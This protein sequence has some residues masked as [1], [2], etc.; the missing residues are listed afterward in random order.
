MNPFGLIQQRFRRLSGRSKAVGMFF[1]TSLT[2]RA[3]GICCQLFQV[4][5]AVKA[6]GAEAFGLWMTL[7][8][9]GIMITFADFGMGQG[10]QNKLAEAF[11]SGNERLARELGGSVAVFLGSLALLLAAVVGV[12]VPLLNFTALFNLTDPVVQAQAPHAILI[13][14]LLFCVNFPLG[15][16]QRLAYSRQR[17]WMHNIA[18][19]LGGLGS[20]GGVL[21][22]ARLHLGLAAFIAAA[23]IPFILANAGLLSLQLIQLGWF[24]LH[25]VHC[26]WA[27]IR[28]LLGLGAYFGVQQVQLVLML[29]LPQLIISTSLGA[30]AVTPYNLAQRLFNLFAIIQNAF[31]LP[32]WPAYSDAKARG[33]FDWIRRTL[34]FSLRATALCTIAPM[35]IGALFA[36]KLLALWVGGHGALPSESLVW[37]L[38]LWNALVFLQQTFGYLLAGLSEVRRLTFYAVIS[39]AASAGLM[40]LLVHHYAQEGVVIGMII[41]FLPYLLLGNIAETIRFFRL[42]YGR[43]KNRFDLVEPAPA[44]AESQT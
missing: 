10:A 18:Q 26:R 28:E 5:V 4:P 38:F 14:L 3:I 44:T 36:K 16:A 17:G 22:A 7:T 30:A 6:L 42:V 9:I 2:A 39:I 25:S 35:A 19:A 29:S 23:Q 33:E 1:A 34:F 27:T 13:T 37:L 31:M 8:S 43:Q 21:L 11:A 41:G 20:L 24:N 40:S 32:L 15:L 12:V